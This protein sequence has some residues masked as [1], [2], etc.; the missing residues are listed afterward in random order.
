MLN[1]GRV[2]VDEE[3]RRLFRVVVY[4]GGYP[5]WVEAGYPTVA[6]TEGGW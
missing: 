5:E 1:P 2:V 3:Q 6:G 4:M